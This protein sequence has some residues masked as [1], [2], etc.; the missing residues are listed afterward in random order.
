MKATEQYFSVVLYIM[1]ARDYAKDYTE[2]LDPGW[3][4]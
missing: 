2:V 3:C 1:M 4:F